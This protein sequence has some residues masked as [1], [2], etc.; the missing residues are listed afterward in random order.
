[1]LT[2]TTTVP[3][4]QIPQETTIEDFLPKLSEK[5]DITIYPINAPKYVQLLIRSIIADF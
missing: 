2:A 4:V 3:K 1:V 5:N